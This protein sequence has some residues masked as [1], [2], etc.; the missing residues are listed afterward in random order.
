MKDTRIDRVSIILQR[1]ADN[2]YNHP[3]SMM[4]V[5]KN[6]KNKTQ[7]LSNLLV[8]ILRSLLNCSLPDMH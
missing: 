6:T 4:R 7:L 1:L 3:E 2:I 8:M 5:C